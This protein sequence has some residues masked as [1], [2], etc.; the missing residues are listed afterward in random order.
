MSIRAHVIALL[1]GALL[2]APRGAA[3]HVALTA[4][5]DAAQAGVTDAPTGAG[6]SATLEYE[7]ETG[8]IT[9]DL[10]LQNLSAAPFIAHIH[11]GAPGVAGGVV[12][13]LPPS[14]VPAG[15]S[16]SANGTMTLPSEQQNALYAGLLY[17]N[18]HTTAHPLGEV[19]GQILV[20]KGTCSCQSATSPGKFKSCVRHA[21]KGLDGEDRK[22]SEIKQLKALVAKASCAK[23]KTPR[24][25]VACCLPDDPEANIVTGQLCAA[26]SAKKCTKLA[27]TN[28][29]AGISCLPTNP[30]GLPAD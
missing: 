11:S 25:A 6:G 24:K 5:I 9:Y 1:A 8:V 29:G 16:G 17:L 18:F 4:T 20:D 15:A 10:Q 2:L 22:S 21:V 19:R 27:G 28:A 12:V 14:G 26:V 23:T 3:A 13:Q 7:P 30:C